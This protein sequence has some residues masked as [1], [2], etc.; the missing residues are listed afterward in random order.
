MRRRAAGASLLFLVPTFPL[1][2]PASSQASRSAATEAYEAQ[3]ARYEREAAARTAR[4]E[5]E[6]DAREA[7]KLRL[8][9]EKADKAR[10]KEQDRGGA[11]NK[12]PPFNF[13]AEKPRMMAAVGQGTQSAQAYVHLAPLFRRQM[14][15]YFLRSLIMALQHV[16]REKESVTINS[17]VATA[18][19][20]AKTDRKAIIRCVPCSFPSPEGG[21]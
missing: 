12:R 7:E 13:E 5:S 20:K 6:R 18:L 10:R 8:A 4:K 2:D 15:T 16:N 17:R 19:E 9:K 1:P 11:K 14:L 21:N 3:Q